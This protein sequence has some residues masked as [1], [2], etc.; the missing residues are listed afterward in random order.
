MHSVF[1]F[2]RYQQ[3]VE[4]FSHKT[5]TIR[6]AFP[7]CFLSGQRHQTIQVLRLDQM[8]VTSNAYTFNIVD[9]LKQARPPYHQKPLAYEKYVSEPTLCKY[10]YLQRCIELNVSLRTATQQRLISFIL[11]EN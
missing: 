10:S 1:N 4:D 9:K 6:I 8:N 3:R 7:L 5:P 11:V 2:I